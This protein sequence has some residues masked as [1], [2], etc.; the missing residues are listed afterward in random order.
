MTAILDDLERLVRNGDARTIVRCCS[1]AGLELAAAVLAAD[2]TARRD[3]GGSASAVAAY[4]AALAKPQE[5]AARRA[6]AE[7]D[8]PPAVPLTVA[9]VVHGAV[10]QQRRQPPPPA[11]APA[12]VRAAT[13]PATAPASDVQAVTTAKLAAPTARAAPSSA[14][15]SLTAA[16]ERL[17]L[18]LNRLPLTR[19]VLEAL[20][21]AGLRPSTSNGI[22]IELNAADVERMASDREA[23]E[24]LL[25]RLTNS[26][27][28]FGYVGGGAISLRR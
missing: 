4:L 28:E 7:P 14:K 13:R 3:F 24:R 23:Q 15:L 9:A 1:P 18:P 26:V 8:R 17:G 6:L 20:R 19:N 16:G 12:E 5:R 25:L 11:A 22:D 21:D 27:R 10:A 2:D